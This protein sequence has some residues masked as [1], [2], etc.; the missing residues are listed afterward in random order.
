MAFYARWHEESGPTQ[1]NPLTLNVNGVGA[2]NIVYMADF[3]IQSVAEDGVLKQNA[4][5]LLVYSNGNFFLIGYKPDKIN[6]STIMYAKYADGAFDIG[7]S[8]QPLYTP[9][10]VNQI[11]QSSSFV[12]TDFLNDRLIPQRVGLYRVWLQAKC[13]ANSVSSMEGYFIGVIDCTDGSI[14]VD[15]KTVVGIQYFKSATLPATKSAMRVEYEVY[16]YDVSSPIYFTPQVSFDT[17][18]GGATSVY[19]EYS[20]FGAE[21]MGL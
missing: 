3:G 19:L 10:Y 18:L 4:I 20:T 6:T 11:D 14:P 7:G 2:V 13:Y 16:L 9:D 21:Y 15:Q 17:V 8:A 1:V 12:K 5:S